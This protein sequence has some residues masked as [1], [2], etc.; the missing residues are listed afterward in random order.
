MEKNKTVG[1]LLL[2]ERNKTLF[3]ML[4]PYHPHHVIHQSEML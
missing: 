4:A 1:K 2:H 3:K